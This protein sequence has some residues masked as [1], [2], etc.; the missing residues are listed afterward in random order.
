VF[1]ATDEVKRSVVSGYRAAGLTDRTDGI[2]F[3]F[4]NG[5]YHIET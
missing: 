2:F 3:L 1:Y 4:D 5:H